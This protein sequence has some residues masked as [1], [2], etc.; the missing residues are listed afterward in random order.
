[1]L[2]RRSPSKNIV[3]ITTL[4]VSTFAGIIWLSGA[5]SI[6]LCQVLVE[7]GITKPK[8]KFHSSRHRPL[9]RTYGERNGCNTGKRGNYHYNTFC[10]NRNFSIGSM[11]EKLISLDTARHLSIFFGTLAS[12]SSSGIL[13]SSLP[14][15]GRKLK[16]E[17]IMAQYPLIIATCRLQASRQKTIKVVVLPAII[18]CLYLHL[19]G[20]SSSL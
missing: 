4:P 14:C 13:R 5:A 16:T 3:S 10:S 6:K 2:T 1:M 8:S 12:C 20:S 15:Y 17:N 9:K 7:L 19:S 18:F 11:D